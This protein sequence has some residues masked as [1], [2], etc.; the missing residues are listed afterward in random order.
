MDKK[1]HLLS[2]LAT[3]SG[4]LEH[5]DAYRLIQQGNLQEYFIFSGSATQ[6]GL[7]SPR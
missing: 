2:D 3:C 5:F 1:E 4:F 7:W 6:L